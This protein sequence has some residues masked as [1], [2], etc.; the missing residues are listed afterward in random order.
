MVVDKSPKKVVLVV[1]KDEGLRQRI[2]DAINSEKIKITTSSFIDDTLDTHSSL[3]LAEHKSSDLLKYYFPLTARHGRTLSVSSTQNE[4]DVVSALMGGSDG[5]IDVDDSDRLLLARVESAFGFHNFSR[6]EVYSIPPFRFDCMKRQV[7]KQGE[8]LGL[9]PKE[10]LFAEYVFNRP[11]SVIKSTD[12]MASVWSAPYSV[13]S[14]SIDTVAYRVRKK[15]QLGT[16]DAGWDIQRVRT[17]G[18]R[19]LPVRTS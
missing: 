7:Y 19:I 2:A 8:S 1:S 10:F 15:M 11:C 12:I 17:V 18:Y 4:S 5:F 16:V 3:V 6:Y 14:R 13:S 9:S